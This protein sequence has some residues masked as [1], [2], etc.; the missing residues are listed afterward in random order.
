MESLGQLRVAEDSPLADCPVPTVLTCK[1]RKNIKQEASVVNP[2][3]S[4]LIPIQ[5][6]I[7][8]KK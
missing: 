2:T 3:L 8:E 7:F 1:I 5:I 6:R 4:V